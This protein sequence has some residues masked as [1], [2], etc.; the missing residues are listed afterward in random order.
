MKAKYSRLFALGAATFQK[1]LYMASPNGEFW[2][3]HEAGRFNRLRDELGQLAAGSGFLVVG[4]GDML[5][6][7]TAFRHGAWHFQTNRGEDYG[8]ALQWQ[9]IIT[10]TLACGRFLSHSDPMT[11]AIASVPLAAQSPATSTRPSIE[12]A[13]ISRFEEP[14][15]TRSASERFQITPALLADLLEEAVIFVRPEDITITNGKVASR[16]RYKGKCWVAAK[17]HKL[18]G[19][20][21]KWR[22]ERYRRYTRTGAASIAFDTRTAYSIPKRITKAMMTQVLFVIEDLPDN[23]H[24]TFG[25][26]GPDAVGYYNSALIDNI[27]RNPS[28]SALGYAMNFCLNTEVDPM[29]ND[30][31]TY[32]IWTWR[33]RMPCTRPSG[34]IFLSARPSARRWKPPRWR[35]QGQ[36]WNG[37]RTSRTTSTCPCPARR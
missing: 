31:C 7:L 29:R 17:V 21:P 2:R 22:F 32:F 26:L 5:A 25:Y 36:G 13:K 1:R 27:L 10:T 33:T 8:L 30:D 34:G 16:G 24:V 6:T 28:V 14:L 19:V 4:T 11:R 3:C 37:Q 12:L 20:L 35:R 23:T 18:R 9:R 15:S